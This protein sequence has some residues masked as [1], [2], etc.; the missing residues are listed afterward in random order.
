V[1][2]SARALLDAGRLAEALH[3]TEAALARDPLDASAWFEKAIALSE[4]GR[5]D[6]AE[7]ACGRA[8]YLAP[9]EPFVHYFTALL[10]LRR[11]DP[12]AAAQA[13]ATAAALAA[14]RPPAEPLA[15]SHGLTAGE[16]RE[17]ARAEAQRLAGAG[18]PPPAR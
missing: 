6:E 2:R 12:A 9:G 3:V 15:L 13:F 14:R 7:E 1:L 11:A 16:V 10:R 18:S 8:L 17:A 5:H 4:L